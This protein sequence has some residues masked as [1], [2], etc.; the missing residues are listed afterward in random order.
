MQK[1]VSL[2]AEVAKLRT[3]TRTLWQVECPKV[4]NAIVAFVEVVRSNHQLS[5]KVGGVLAKL[6]R[7]RLDGDQLFK[8]WKGRED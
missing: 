3:T 6:L 4:D 8:H 2:E 7:T 5:F 1:V